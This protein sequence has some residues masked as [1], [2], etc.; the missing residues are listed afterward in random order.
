MQI[1]TYGSSF[2]LD[3]NLSVKNCLVCLGLL[4]PSLQWG[5]EAPMFFKEPYFMI[6]L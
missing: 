4:Y 5:V 1:K 3:M 2:H 6:L